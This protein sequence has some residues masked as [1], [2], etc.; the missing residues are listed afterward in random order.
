M[1]DFPERKAPISTQAVDLVRGEIQEF[2][3]FRLGKE[4]RSTRPRRH[5][6]TYTAPRFADDGP[7]HEPVAS[8]FRGKGRA[9][10][11]LCDAQDLGRLGE[12]DRHV[13]VQLSAAQKA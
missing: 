3:G 7:A 4:R 6:R 9:E 10:V 8:S 1:P 13:R 11:V 12:S 2:C 5:G